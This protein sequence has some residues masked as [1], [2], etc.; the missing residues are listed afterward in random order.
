MAQVG[1]KHQK[2]AHRGVFLVFET[3]G[4]GEGAY[5]TQKTCPSRAC[6]WCSMSWEGEDGQTPQ[7]HPQ[8]RISGV[9]DRIEGERTRRKPKHTMCGVFGCSRRRGIEGTC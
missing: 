4:K 8:G 2:R 9:R 3:K 7:T 1:A 6:F 5:Q